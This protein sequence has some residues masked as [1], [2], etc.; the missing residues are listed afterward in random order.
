MAYDGTKP[1]TGT[2]PVSSEIREN[3]RALKE[4]NIVDAKGFGA[5]VDKS[6]SYGAQ[7]ATTDGFVIAVGQIASVEHIYFY[8]DSSADPAT[9]RGELYQN[10]AAF[11]KGTITCPVKKNDYWKIVVDGAN[12][13][14]ERVYWIPLGS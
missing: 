13:T 3:F 4:D 6:A 2:S 11:I 5:W 9:L 7:Q 1:V 8:T 14:I 10:G 12:A